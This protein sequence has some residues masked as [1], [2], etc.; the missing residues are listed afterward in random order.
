MYWPRFQLTPNEAKYNSIYEE[1]SS[2]RNAVLRRIYAGELNLNTTRRE[3]QETIQNSR[4]SR[5][6]ALTA[7]GD[8]NQFEVNIADI[9][10]EQY[11]VGFIPLSN[12][13]GGPVYDP[14]GAIAFNP[15]LGTGG[16][17]TGTVFAGATT[18][19]PYV[20]E[21]SV[22]LAPNQTL[23]VTGRPINPE[24]TDDLHVDLCFHVWEFPNPA[25]GS[26]L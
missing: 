12:L 18:Y 14:R 23:T 22:V 25:M 10:G 19:I 26:P 3:D 13:I 1:P 24:I 15:T 8:T 6:F 2:N 5:V 21:P 7:S 16:L 4:R 20:F 11:T 9:T 17:A